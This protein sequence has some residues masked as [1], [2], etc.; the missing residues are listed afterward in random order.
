M[1]IPVIIGPF[2][3]LESI[4]TAFAAE[5]KGYILVDIAL[6]TDVAVWLAP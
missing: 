6:H 3:P 1:E 5:G 4:V 2:R